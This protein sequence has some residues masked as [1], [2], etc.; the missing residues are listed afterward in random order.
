MIILSNTLAMKAKNIK[1]FSFNMQEAK[2]SADQK[3][4]DDRFSEIIENIGSCIKQ[5]YLVVNHSGFECTEEIKLHLKHILDESRCIIEQ[6]QVS[7]QRIANLQKELK[8]I[9]SELEKDWHEYFI[10]ETSSIN[11]I[12]KL[13][14]NISN[15][16]VNRIRNNIRCAESWYE[17]NDVKKIETFIRSLSEAKDVINKLELNEDILIFLKKMVDYS[18][19]VSDLTEEVLT[20]LKKEKLENRV[21]ISF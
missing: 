21:K 13:A 5:V 20:W 15:V 11:E 2:K 1:Q 4:I 3:K 9:Q 18:A 19:T 10:E 16:D 8:L 14:Q 7:S 17:N 12:L 6:Q